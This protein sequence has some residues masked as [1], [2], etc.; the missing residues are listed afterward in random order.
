MGLVDGRVV[1]VTG[2]GRGIGRAHA[3]AFAA[4]GARVV[5]NDIGVGLDGSAGDSPADEVVEEVTSAGGEAVANGDDIAD[6][7]GAASL[8]K[9][10]L[11]TFGRLDVLVNNAGFIR[12][13]M[14]ANTSEEEWDAVIRVHLKGHFAALRHAAEYWRAQSKAGE[15]VDARIINTSSAAG[16]QGS[17]GQGNYSAAK[18]GIAALTLVAAAELGRYGVTVNAIAPAARTRMTEKVFADTM[19]RP[20]DGFDAMAPE[21]VSPLVVWLG[22]AESKDVTGK[23]FEV[24]GGLIRVAEGWAHGPQLDKGARWDPVELGPVVAD[25]LSKAR[26]PVPVYGA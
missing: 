4:E 11:D 23:V 10:A 17:I 8:V 24:E 9:T 7:S 25:L 16:L 21:N 14:L 13:R 5:V 26:P 22:S 6:W 2:A 20:E 19:S 3:L 18:A 12:D 15:A 1:V